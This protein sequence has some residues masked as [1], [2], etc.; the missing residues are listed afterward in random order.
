MATTEAK[1]AS[2]GHT[3][4]PWKAYGTAVWSEHE[5]VSGKATK[6]TRTNHVC[7]VSD[8]LKMPDA[9]RVA[10]ARLIALAPELLSFVLDVMRG[11]TDREDL[12]RMAARLAV[13]AGV[14]DE[15]PGQCAECAR[16]FGPHY[17]GPC[18]H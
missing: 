8:R 4:G 14:E 15:A 6:G 10:N 3:P 5:S 11:C 13:R 1:R 2:V 16:S 12:E 7:A 9:E 17:T 18:A